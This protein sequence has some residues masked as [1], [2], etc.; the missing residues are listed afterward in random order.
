MSP[1][2][3]KNIFDPCYTTKGVGEGT[4]MGLAVAYG[5]AKKCNGW[6]GVRREAG[7]LQHGTASQL[8]SSLT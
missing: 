8:K 1:E 7:D 2:I 4:G 3:L 6:I 5:L